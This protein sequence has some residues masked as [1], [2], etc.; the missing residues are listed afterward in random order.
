MEFQERIR[1]KK[2]REKIVVLTAYDYQMAKILDG[3][4]ID[5]IL[6]GDSVGMVVQ[7]HSNTKSVTMN[8]M[9]YHVKTVARGAKETPIIGDMP[10]NSCNTVEDA[11]RNAKQFLEAGAHGVKIEGNRSEVVK[12]LIDAGIPV[13]GHVGMLPQMAET[14]RVKGKEPEEAEEIFRDALN[15]DELGVFS[16]VLEC[17]PQSLAK[18]ITENVKAPTIGIGAGKYCDGQVLVVNDMLGLDESFKP[19]YVKRYA[20][21]N[22]IIKDAVAK[23]VEEV[24]AGNYPDEKHTYH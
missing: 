20:S 24:S 10:I 13:M 19:K 1:R 6:V 16:I 2:G 3:T 23:F 7:G 17:M 9:I 12:A 21:L 5:L 4:G 8:D 11:L 18:R 15:L 14:Y 22:E